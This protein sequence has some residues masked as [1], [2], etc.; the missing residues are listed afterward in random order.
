[1]TSGPTP[2]SV[3]T[4]IDLGNAAL[5]AGLVNVF[6]VDIPLMPPISLRGAKIFGEF[7]C[8]N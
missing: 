5:P 6:T 7:R 2:Q 8:E 1:M 4:Q 3:K